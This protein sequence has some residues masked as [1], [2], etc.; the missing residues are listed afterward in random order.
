MNTP[1]VIRIV[2]WAVCSLIVAAIIAGL[3]VS[4]SPATRRRLTLD[5]RRVNSLSQLSSGIDAYAQTKRAIPANLEALTQDQPYL[6]N[7]VRDPTTGSFYSYIPLAGSTSSY[8]LC[9]TFDLPSPEDVTNPPFA[10]T[11]DLWANPILSNHTAGNV[12]YTLHVR[13]LTPREP[14][15]PVA[16]PLPSNL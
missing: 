15:P 12:C 4:G 8:Q 2:R 3:Y 10:P 11:Q 7:E 16:K 14:L 9:A 13:D 1:S 6:V 5:E